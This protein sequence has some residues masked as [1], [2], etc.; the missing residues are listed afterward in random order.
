VLRQFH[1]LR[2]CVAPLEALSVYSGPFSYLECELGSFQQSSRPQG[3][4]QSST[5][6]QIQTL[7]LDIEGF[8]DFL[9]RLM[10]SRIL[11]LKLGNS[12]KERLLLNL[13][14]WRCASDCEGALFRTG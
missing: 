1:S 4:E 9:E 11:P 14:A 5:V 8:L 13:F 12:I 2:D 3:L 10:Q 6:C 7:S